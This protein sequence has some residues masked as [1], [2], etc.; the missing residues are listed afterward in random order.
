VINILILNFIFDKKIMKI[1]DISHL[2]PACIMELFG[3]TPDNDTVDSIELTN[4]KGMQLKV[5]TYGATITSLKM[6]L[7]RGGFVDV[8]L[9]FDDLESYINSFDLESPPYFG[10]TIGR[11]AGRI[12]KGV[13]SLNGN[14]IHLN[15]NNNT[16]SLHGGNIGFS[17]RIWKVK[18]VTEGKNP[19]VTLTYLSPNNEENYPG[20][21]SVNLTYTVS[22]E[23]ELIVEY[24]ATTNQD[25]IINLTHHSYFN[26]DGHESTI[27]NQDLRVNSVRVLDT[28]PE[29]IPTGWFLN[30]AHC[31]FDFRKPKACPKKID[32][33]FVLKQNE[34]FA[35]SLFNKKNNL[36]MS[37]YTNQPAV[38]VYV[39][40]NCFN[41]IKGKENADYNSLSGICFE[42]QNFPDAPNHEHFPSSILRKEEIYYHKTIYKF[43]SF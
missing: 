9:G 12:N 4:K 13:F 6:P 32:S 8:V 39:G 18:K 23:N 38:H 43:Q 41:T 31:P 40:G 20:D 27:N 19:S 14:L 25:T 36:R 11:Y 33:T 1:K 2:K 21:L 30:V 42:T 24:T 22:E 16:N 26:L 7:K 28:T 29:N 34:E 37:V 35:A 17:Q 5:I 3:L 15:K 10:A